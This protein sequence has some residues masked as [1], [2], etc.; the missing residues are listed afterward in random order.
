MR[1]GCGSLPEVPAL[2]AGLSRRQFSALPRRRTP[3]QRLARNLRPV[4]STPSSTNE[5]K[6]YIC[7]EFFLPRP[8]R[9]A[10]YCDDRVCL[11]VCLS[12]V[13]IYLDHILGSTCPI[14]TKFLCMLPMAVA[15]SS[16]DGI[17]IRYVLPVLRMTSYLLM[18]QGC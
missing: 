14:F 2:L 10:E 15:L 3:R 11:C 13:I 18:S 8:D 9:G 7:V 1:R 16:S 6:S 5:Q 17:V 12:V 4:S